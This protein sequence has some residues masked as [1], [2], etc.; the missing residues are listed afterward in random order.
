MSA[1]LL[2]SEPSVYSFDQLVAD[3]KTAWSGVRNFQA[4]NHL[5]AMKKGDVALFFHTGDE[6]ALVGVARIASAPGPDP[7]APGEDWTSVDVVPVT[8]LTEP[9]PLARIKATPALASLAMI[10][11]GRLSVSPVSD[12]ELKALLALGK[13]RL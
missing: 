7:T 11:Q 3:K 13:T 4:R 6:K 1:W 2:K 12:A 5:R 10:K 8:R 9:V